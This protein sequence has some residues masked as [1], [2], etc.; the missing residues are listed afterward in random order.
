MSNSVYLAIPLMLLLAVIQT[1]VLPRFPVFGLTPNLLFLV[2]LAW[3]VVRGWQEG[4]VWAFVAGIMADLFS[5][6]PLGLSSLTFMIAIGAALLL[7]RPFPSYPLLAP[8][9]A[10]AAGTLIYLLLQFLLLRVFGFSM[11]PSAALS[12]APTILFHALLILP[13]Y[14]IMQLVL[15]AHRP[16]PVE[17]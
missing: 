16:R 17:F 13:I 9:A 6:T 11:S 8:M 5:L 14:G 12:L 10:A 2:A 7:I 4:V 3:G 1:A 15:R